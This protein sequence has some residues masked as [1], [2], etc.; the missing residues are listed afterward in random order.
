MNKIFLISFC[1]FACSMAHVF[2]NGKH[3]DKNVIVRYWQPSS[4][5]MLARVQDTT[6]CKTTFVFERKFNDSILFTASDS[7][8]FNGRIVTNRNLSVC[9]KFIE[10]G[11]LH[12]C[13]PPIIKVAFIESPN[14]NFI[15]RLRKGYR[16]CYVNKTDTVITLDYSNYIREYY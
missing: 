15:H 12:N 16:Y 2:Q 9:E 13:L 11:Y 5:S 3:D 7:T 8:I 4:N 1:F 14:Y 10:V 6:I